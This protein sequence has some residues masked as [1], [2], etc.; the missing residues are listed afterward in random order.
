MLILDATTKS[1][2]IDLNGAVATNELDV[3]THYT[4]ITTTAY[5]PGNTRTVTNGTTAVTI[6][7]AP[8]ASTQR[9][10]ETISVYNKDTAS[11]TVTI[12][13]NDNST[14]GIIRKH[15]LLT[16]EHLEYEAGKGWQVFTAAGDLKS[17][18]GVTSLTGTANEI[19]ASPG[20]GAVVL[21][22][23]AA[24]TFTG[25]TVTGG[26]FASPTLQTPA[27]GTP[28]SGVA[29]NLPGTAAGLTA[30]NVTTNA[31]LTGPITSV[32]NATAVAAQTGT[33]STFVMQASPS[34]TTPEIGTATG[35][36]L[37]LTGD[38]AV[39]GG[40]LTSTAT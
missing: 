1:I 10:I 13:E 40:D 24:L 2:E 19:T 32:G 36:A 5:T 33:G 7:A 30:G 25:K 27:L 28:A 37:T 6:V 18:G 29:T 16:L 8:A 20:S 39:N 14:L 22:L 17:T 11:A 9:H 4:D 23:P 26:T 15:T 35:V 38:L 21:S 12:Q 34:F 31:N 3:T